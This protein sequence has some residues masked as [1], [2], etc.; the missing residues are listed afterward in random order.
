MQ[1]SKAFA[2]LLLLTTAFGV[3]QPARAP[4]YG[5][6]PFGLPTGI[7]SGFAAIADFNGDGY[8][9]I[10]VGDRQHLVTVVL[11]N[12]DGTFGQPIRTGVL[13]GTTSLA[14]T[15]LNGDGKFD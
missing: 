12:G 3:A 4:S 5:F 15:D 9:D 6:T 14:A 1:I 8:L 13:G 10:V 11:G 2:S 7:N